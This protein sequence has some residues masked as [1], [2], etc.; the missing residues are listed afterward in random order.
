[1]VDADAGVAVGGTI[2]ISSISSSTVSGSFDL[3]FPNGG[4]LSGS[5]N[6]ALCNG[7]TLVF[8]YLCAGNPVG[9]AG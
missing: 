8:A 7:G 5:F 1:M 4:K 2:D 6:S 3:S 9:C